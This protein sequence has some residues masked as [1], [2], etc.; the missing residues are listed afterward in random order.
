MVKEPQKKM[1]LGGRFGDTPGST[2]LSP[3]LPLFGLCPLT[4]SGLHPGRPPLQRDLKGSS[5]PLH[6]FQVTVCMLLLLAGQ[7]SPGADVAQI[8]E[9]L[10]L[11][12]VDKRDFISWVLY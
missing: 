8:E 12:C 9:F 6:T 10:H 11:P 2:N 1:S 4:R 5:K 7:T 3:S